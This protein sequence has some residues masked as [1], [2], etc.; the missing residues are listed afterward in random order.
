M[1]EFVGDFFVAGK[2]RRKKGGDDVDMEGICVS[3]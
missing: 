2:G 3:I 1:L